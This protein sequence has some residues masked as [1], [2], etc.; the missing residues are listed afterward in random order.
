[1][2]TASAEITADGRYTSL[3]ALRA[4]HVRL[5]AQERTESGRPEF[6]E[7]VREFLY[8]GSATGAL[9]YDHNDRRAAQSLLDY[10]AAGLYVPGDGLPMAV[11]E[12]FDLSIAPE[13][14]DTPAPY[15]G[16]DPFDEQT[17]DRFFGRAELVDAMIQ[18]LH[19]RRML[20]VVG[21]SG[22]GKSSVVRAGVLP[23]LARPGPEGAPT[24]RVLPPILPGSNPLESLVATVYQ[25]V[26]RTPSAPAGRVSGWER[27][28]V[29]SLSR[30]LLDHSLT[31]SALLDT[32][33]SQPVVITVDQ[34]EEVFTL[35]RDEQVRAVF[36][37]ELAGLVSDERSRHALIITMRSDFEDN[38]AR[39]TTLK[40][41]FDA[42]RVQVTALNIAQLR[43]AIEEPARRVGLIFDEGIVDDLISDALGE[44]A[45][46]P[47]L[48]F[49]LSKLWENRVRNRVTKEVYYRV[50]G[51]GEALSRS[52][53]RW[54]QHLIPQ[55]QQTARRILM[56]LVRPA[57][58]VLVAAEAVYKGERRKIE[59]LLSE[60]REVLRTRRR[61]QEL[62]RTGEDPDNI[63]QVLDGMVKER[64]VRLSPGDTP[65]DDQIEVAH[66]ALI[67]NWKT[68]Q[69][70]INEDYE[71]LRQ[72][73]RLI[74]AANMWEESGRDPSRLWRGAQLEDARR[75][76]FRDG[77]VGPF[78]DAGRAEEDRLFEER[79]MA[80][81]RAAEARAAAAE[82]S[83]QIA[84]ARAAE[85]EARAAEAEANAAK[86]FERQRAQE[87]AR[88]AKRLR[89]LNLVLALLALAAVV[90]GLLAFNSALQEAQA[91]NIADE[92]RQTANA[93]AAA[94]ATQRSI[95]ETQWVIAETS[96]A[97][98]AV[99]AL[100]AE[101][102]RQSALTAEAR[103]ANEAANAVS[104]RKTAEA[105]RAAAETAAA[106]YAEAV[107][108]ANALNDQL[109]QQRATAEVAQTA[110]AALSA[111]QIAL[112]EADLAKQE[113][114]RQKEEENR[115]LE[116]NSFV[117]R[118]QVLLLDRNSNEAQLREA[119]REGITLADRIG[120][121]A[122]VM[123]SLQGLIQRLEDRGPPEQQIRPLGPIT[124]ATWNNTGSAVLVASGT[125]ATVW[126]ADT[127]SR[128]VPTL[129]HRANVRSAAW[130]SDGT[131]I[132]SGDSDGGVYVWRAADGERLIT[133]DGHSRP[134]QGVAW[135]P[136]D[137][138][139]VSADEAE[140]IVWD[141]ASGRQLGR[142]AASGEQ[143]TRAAWSPDGGNFVTAGPELRLRDGLNGKLLAGRPVDSPVVSAAWSPD[144]QRILTANEA[145]Q[146][147]IWAAAGLVLQR[148]L[149]GNTCDARA[150]MWSRTGTY[151]VVGCGDGTVRTFSA[152]TGELTNTMYGHTS[153]VRSVTW[154]P[155]GQRIV[156]AGNDGRVRIFFYYA[157]AVLR[158]ARELQ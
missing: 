147:Q 43:E 21:T 20:A 60:G 81:A 103:R 39:L 98:A 14:P 71:Q 33:G 121:A 130:S 156:T 57:D 11:L 116:V 74:E 133:F 48:Q 41:L 157:D 154:S 79:R 68:L 35:C 152:D 38:V 25:A 131:R 155:D 138:R 26:G 139:I 16:L 96:E 148:T 125:E 70:W 37:A 89:N 77:S 62:F 69:G 108:T 118:T 9:L 17:R 72:R 100:T 110:F 112:L 23:A 7:R 65:A 51:M 91:R 120:N 82:A 1:M 63:S 59:R 53:D 2:T 86:N 12:P 27:R 10:W 137:Q 83:Q 144:G 44:S 46:L 136:D 145:G 135:S 61:K 13:L 32:W 78:L 109:S 22:S 134:V 40:P 104:S 67:R 97:N 30:G 153:A 151:L 18:Q 5:L 117:N 15:I 99:A 42:T 129:N 105:E 146:V 123:D 6:V 34:F 84:E 122:L 141:V 19:S 49:T 87:Q 28:V 127:R 24:W 93:E 119:L 75:L 128:T 4:A 126:V 158:R 140:V 85:A 66:E 50:G 107:V 88:T 142:E 58:P 36:A 64:L 101:A 56:E 115:R 114:L 52:A 31:L 54:Y 95:A 124:S 113:E 102:G 73:G 76:G 106:Q 90:A 3:H 111:T 150:A 92:Q 94:A 149:T 80:A 45:A 55:Q 132:V 29:A 8:Q 47:L 143:L